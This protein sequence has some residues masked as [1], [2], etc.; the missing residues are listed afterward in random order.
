[1]ALT[2]EELQEL[3]ELEEMELLE[4]ASAQ[5]GEG[6]AD[7]RA[8]AIVPVKNDSALGQLATGSA[9]NLTGLAELASGAAGMVGDSL[10][11]WAGDEGINDLNRPNLVETAVAMAQDPATATRLGGS[12]FGGALGSMVGPAGT[13]AGAGAGDFLASQA[14]QLIGIQEDTPILEDIGES[15]TGG[16]LD[17]AMLGAGKAARGLKSLPSI[18]RDAIR[19]LKQ[20]PQAAASRT[21]GV[22]RGSS[23]KKELIAREFDA[24]QPHLD[25]MGFYDEMPTDLRDL[26][27]RAAAMKEG[28]ITERNTMAEGIE[29]TVSASGYRNTEAVRAMQ[30]DIDNK[31]R[32]GTAE[33]KESAMDLQAELDFALADYEPKTRDYADTISAPEFSATD[34]TNIKTAQQKAMLAA[35]A[36]NPAV[37]MDPSGKA[38]Q[39]AKNQS[40][41]ANTMQNAS[42]ELR[43]GLDPAGGL[44]ALDTKYHHLTNAE[45]GLRESLSGA[46]LE[47]AGM[48]KSGAA[49][50]SIAGRL[51]V[52]ASGASGAF[53][54]SVDAVKSMAGGGSVAGMQAD[55]LLR[56]RTQNSAVVLKKMSD[57]RRGISLEQGV[58][59]RG[60]QVGRAAETIGVTSAMIPSFYG[61]EDVEQNALGYAEGIYQGASQPMDGE[62]A[63]TAHARASAMAQEFMKVMEQG[64][65]RDK[66]SIIASMQKMGLM[67]PSSP[68][69]GAVG[70]PGGS[71]IELPEDRAKFMENMKVDLSSG[72]MDMVTYAKQRQAMANP[73]NGLIIES[74]KLPNQ[75]ID[76]KSLLGVVDP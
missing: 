20:D 56:Q 17:M 34:L 41:I 32:I 44:D 61:T 62:T 1:M 31:L 70:G 53:N 40:A 15:L 16:A 4:Q 71:F 65:T 11:W 45:K 12:V 51:G 39:R 35:D 47:A 29:G 68:I 13:I 49:Q 69:Q 52:F 67:P 75:G 46:N 30:A 10:G 14:N 59:Q 58:T 25:K 23:D 36:F 18:D 3:Q 38:A 33:M 24:A 63:E 2:P 76:V 7:A 8:A 74:E 26:E 50:G 9:K 54:T 27:G 66:R 5:R 72:T 60:Q 37:M 28:A 73:S 57:I 43:G 64:H 48:F 42:R 19:A 21:A 22:L 55:R 6:R